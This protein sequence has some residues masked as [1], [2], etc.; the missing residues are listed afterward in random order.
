MKKIREAKAALEEEARREA[1]EEAHRQEERTEER[2]KKEAT[3]GHRFGGNPPRIPDPNK[4]VPKP[5][6]QKNFT[7]PE[8]CLMVDG[9]SGG[10]IGFRQFSLRGLEAVGDEWRII[11]LTHN[12][13]KL[14]R[15]GAC[16]KPA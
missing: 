7:D 16:V 12:L 10:F 9:A 3:Q 15:A 5:T 4:A 2:K 14:F 8:S 11:C 6:K 13:L 1:E